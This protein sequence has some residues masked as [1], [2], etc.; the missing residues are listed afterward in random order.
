MGNCSPLLGPITWCS[1]GG[2]CHERCSHDNHRAAC[3]AL[4]A[5]TSYTPLY[6]P[7]PTG[8]PVTGGGGTAGFQDTGLALLG[9]AAIA[10][11][12]Y[13]GAPIEVSYVVATWRRAH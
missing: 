3:V 2:K 12:R 7:V 1:C 10:E 13:S 6:T 8:A 4:S 11:L 9:G 5:C